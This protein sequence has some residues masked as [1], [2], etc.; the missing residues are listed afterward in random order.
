MGH[1]PS[2]RPEL[3]AEHLGLDSVDVGAQR[4]YPGPVGGGAARFPASAPQNLGFPSVGALAKL[5]CQTALPDPRLAADQ[6]SASMPRPSTYEGRL[7]L[8]QLTFATDEVRCGFGAARRFGAGRR[9]PLLP[10]GVHRALPSEIERGIL[11]QDR[12]VEALKLL[13]G[14]YP[15]LFDQCLASAPVSVEGIGLPARSVQGQHQ[16]AARTLAQRLGPHQALELAHDVRV[17]TAFE[18]CRDTVLE[19]RDLAL[20]E[21]LEGEVGQRRPAPQRQGVAQ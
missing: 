19:P 18:I 11:P 9:S 17:A 13:A 12:L 10:L 5:G 1:F 3:I 20:G 2:T 8:S 7:E 4:L 15:E 21:G 16:L 6:V 14:L